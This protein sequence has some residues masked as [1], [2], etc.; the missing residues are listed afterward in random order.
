MKKLI[1]TTLMSAALAF[2]FSAQ[3]EEEKTFEGT[4]SC[5]KCNLK[6][7][8][9]CADALQFEKDGKTVTYYLEENGKVKTSAHKCS[10]TVPAK[11]TGKMEDRDGKTFV[12]ASKIELK[13]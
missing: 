11:V 4:M 12:V 7:A 1:A 2:V 3:A 9:A 6:E 8:K 10:G 5:A 13:K